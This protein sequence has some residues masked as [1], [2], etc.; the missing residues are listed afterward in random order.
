MKKSIKELGHRYFIV[1]L[2]GMAYGLFASLIIGV[3]LSQLAKIPVLGFL[4]MFNEIL[5]PSSPVVGCA[6]GMAVSY[7]LE[8]NKLALFSCAAVGAIGYK[9]GGPVA[10]Y[11]ACVC[12]SELGTLVSGKTPM[13]IVLV[14]FVT[15]ITGGLVAQFL[16]Q[17]ISWFMTFLGELVNTATML[18]PFLMGIVISVLMGIFLTAPISSAAIAIS[19]GL[20]GPA[21]GAATVGCCVHMLGFA[22]I[23]YQENGIGG[24]V[25][26]GLGT[27]MLQVPN[28]IKHPL[29]ILPPV[30]VSAL[31]GP[32]ATTLI[33]IFNTPWG[34]GMGTSGLVGVFGAY[35]A[36]TAQGISSVVI[37]ARIGGLLVLAPLVL[38]WLVGMVMRKYK[39]IKSGDLKL[40]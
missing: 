12:A 25:A 21:A 32:L 17:P 9:L 30:I 24:F 20:S 28:I 27:S 14:P 26:Q 8:S 10:C 34:A 11:V 36:M 35:E 37:F 18:Q 1:A 33:P 40:D 3:I 7:S 13:D 23:S 6:I 29:T 16:G 15:I 2:S 31:L 19:L 39:W 22:I 4:G 5:A 38:C